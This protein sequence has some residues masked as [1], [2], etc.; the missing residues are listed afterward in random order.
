MKTTKQWI[1][2]LNLEA[3]PKGRYFKQ[4]DYLA[5]T[6]LKNVLPPFKR[7]FFIHKVIV[8]FTNKKSN[9]EKI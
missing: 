2:G 7:I 6:Y 5:Q 9:L 1:E 8:A 3:H 4:T